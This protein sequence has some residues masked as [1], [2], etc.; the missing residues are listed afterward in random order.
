MSE[1]LQSLSDRELVV[2]GITAYFMVAAVLGCWI[3]RSGEGGAE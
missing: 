1:F 3:T 2:A